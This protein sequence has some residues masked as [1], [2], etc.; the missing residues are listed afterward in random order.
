M[1]PADLPYLSFR[2]TSVRDVHLAFAGKKKSAPSSAMIQF[3]R[4]RIGQV[5]ARWSASKTLHTPRGSFAL[6]FVQLG[7]LLLYGH[8]FLSLCR[9]AVVETL[10]V[11]KPK[12][13]A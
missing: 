7:I 1:L 10:S 13:S 9:T 8:S 3:S 11:G 12:T 4:N 2:R 6:S 5:M